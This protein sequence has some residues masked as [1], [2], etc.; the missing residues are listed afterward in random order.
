MMVDIL[1]RVAAPVLRLTTVREV[2]HHRTF[3]AFARHLGRALVERRVREE[4]RI[5]SFPRRRAL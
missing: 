1:R 5:V 3:G 4:P 2:D